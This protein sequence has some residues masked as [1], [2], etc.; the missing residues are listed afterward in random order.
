MPYQVVSVI[1]LMAYE[2][3]KVEGDFQSINEKQ[4][5]S[6]IPTG[7]SFTGFIDQLK[8]GHLALLADTPSVPLL[9]PDTENHAEKQWKL[10]PLVKDNIDLTAQNTFLSRI[11]M[12]GYGG[13]P[14]K[15]ESGKMH[16]PLPMPPYTPEPVVPLESERPKSPKY[17]YNVEVA[18]SRECHQKVL[19]CAFRLSGTKQERLIGEYQMKHLGDRTRYTFYFMED[20]P[21]QLACYIASETLGLRVPNVRPCPVGSGIVR[22]I[23][24]PVA[25][26]VQYSE[27]LGLPTKGYYYHIAD[28]R[29]VQEYK[30][31]SEELN[32]SEETA[33]PSFY[34]TRTRHERL[35]TVRGGNYNQ[36]AILVYGKVNNQIVENQYLIYLEKPVTRDEL[37]N[38]NEA[39]LLE[40]GVKLDIEALLNIREESAVARPQEEQ[41]PEKKAEVTTHTVQMQPGSTE[42]ESWPQIAEQYNLTPVELLKLNP[43]YD[44]DPS[45]LK[46]GD[47][48]RIK[49]PEVRKQEPVF[50]LPPISPSQYN[51]FDNS[52]YQYDQWF[53]EGSRLKSLNENFGDREVPLVCLNAQSEAADKSECTL[54]IGVF[55]DGTGQNSPNDEYKESFGNKSR[56]NVARLFDAYPSI[57]GKSEKIYI[58]G[59]GTVDNIPITPGE[60]NP[61]IDAGDDEEGLGQAVG[62]LTYTG[63]LWKWQTL[64]RRMRTILTTLFDL[65]LY[66]KINHIEFDVFG[67][68]RGAALAR[69]FVNAVHAGLPDFQ[70]P[71][72]STSTSELMPNLLGNER[73]KRFSSSSDEFYAV[74]TRRKASVRFVGLFDTVG[75]FYLPGMMMK[76]F[77][78]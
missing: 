15:E 33:V 18:L 38:I 11:Q 24:I 3:A 59:V 66:Q 54:R 62:M 65:G 40:H 36:K 77:I 17:E 21:K 67:F 70:N 9:I 7:M 23:L 8:Q 39:W 60:R 31:V 44:K 47:S 69:H 72:K 53:L 63:A 22:E 57:E 37:D 13:V 1:N 41:T 35:D 48:L 52:Y 42:R 6:V 16:P 46:V 50:E 64:L 26:A 4:L 28:N 19:N 49:K 51:L 78:A 34:A 68:S 5:S 12:T 30:I 55:F 71:E 32:G 56:T 61:V 58:S 74:D 73:Y 14:A 27:R 43:V 2:F 10:N 75:S 29:L 45:S 76:A 25:P 20:E